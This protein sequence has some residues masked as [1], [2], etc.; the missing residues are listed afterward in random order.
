VN[1][2]ISDPYSTEST[3]IYHSTDMISLSP[4][5]LFVS[6]QY[7]IQRR[8]SKFSVVHD[9]RCFGRLEVSAS[10][11]DDEGCFLSRGRAPRYEVII[12]CFDR[13]RRLYNSSFPKHSDQ[14]SPTAGCSRQGEVDA[15]RRLPNRG[16]REDS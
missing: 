15:R 6:S 3:S 8:N 4:T 10:V 9:I 1:E 12:C 14:D 11:C 5:S 13:S 2:C 7:L 16:P